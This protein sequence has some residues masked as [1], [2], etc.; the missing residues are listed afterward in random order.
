MTAARIPR[1][2]PEEL[3]DVKLWSDACARAAWIVDRGRLDEWL[4]DEV[5]AVS[6]YKLKLVSSVNEQSRDLERCD[7]YTCHAASS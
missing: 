4:D 3:E 1:L 2:L 5:M 6:R 7:I